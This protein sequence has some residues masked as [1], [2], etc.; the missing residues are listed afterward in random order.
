V[1]VSDVLTDSCSHRGRSYHRPVAELCCGLWHMAVGLAAW[2]SY[3]PV[4]MDRRICMQIMERLPVEP[5]SVWAAA[6]GALCC[7]K[8]HT[9]RQPA[10]PT[11][12]GNSSHIGTCSVCP[13]TIVPFKMCGSKPDQGWYCS[14]LHDAEHCSKHIYVSMSTVGMPAA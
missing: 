9:P 5:P 14:S 1:A 3:C 11:I 13:V 12:T 2:R 8:R 7:G 4:G 6:Q 10:V